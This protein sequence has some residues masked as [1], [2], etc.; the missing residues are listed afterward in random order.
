MTRAIDNELTEGQINQRSRQVGDTLRTVGWKHIR[1]EL[2]RQLD[3]VER[4]ILAGEL[5]DDDYRRYCG[6][7]EGL[8]DALKAPATLIHEGDESDA[9]TG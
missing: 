8:M 7:R 5:D 3:L 9:G 1:V 6:R 2:E 4:K